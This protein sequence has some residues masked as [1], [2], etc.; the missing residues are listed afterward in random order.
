MAIKLS[1]SGKTVFKKFTMEQIEEASELQAGFCLACG[2]MRDMVEPDA[3]RY[4]CELCSLNQ[5]YGAE[6]IFMMGL[7]IGE[8]TPES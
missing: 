4:K 2:E 5:V 8:Q 6:E 7:V 1:A 3:R